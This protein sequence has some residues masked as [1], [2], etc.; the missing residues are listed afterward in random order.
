MSDPDNSRY[1]LLVSRRAMEQGRNLHVYSLHDASGA[2]MAGGWNLNRHRLTAKKFFRWLDLSEKHRHKTKLALRRICL[3]RIEVLRYIVESREGPL[4]SCDSEELLQP[5]FYGIFR[6]E[7]GKGYEYPVGMDDS[8]TFMQLDHCLC[9]GRGAPYD[10]TVQNRLQE[11][12]NEMSADL[13]ELASARDKGRCCVTGRSDLPTTVVWIFPPRAGY[14]WDLYQTVRYE[15]Y[16]V[17][18][19]VMTICSALVPAFYQN[20]FSVDFGDAQTIVSFATL[21]DGTPEL[22]S[23]LP[24]DVHAPAHFWTQSFAFTLKVHFPGGGGEEDFDGYNPVA[25]MDEL[26]ARQPQLDDPKWQTPYGREVF[27]VYLEQ[28]MEMKERMQR[29]KERPFKMPASWTEFDPRDASGYIHTKEDYMASLRQ[30]D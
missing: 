16:R 11:R 22:P 1:P 28:E 13:V 12:E 5:G 30:T 29:R 8:V 24:G 23:H 10:A 3:R 17:V 2:V 26:N 25:W 14:G 20:L 7:D 9:V 4:I 18:E 19:N 15:D 27:E 6:A 21:P